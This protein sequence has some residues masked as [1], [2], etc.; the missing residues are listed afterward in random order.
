MNRKAAGI[1]LSIAG[2]ALLAGILCRPSVRPMSPER[3]VADTP[4]AGAASFSDVSRPEVAASQPRSLPSA[5]DFRISPATSPANPE[6][7]I[8]PLGFDGDA[9][10][11]PGERA[12]SEKIVALHGEAPLTAD[13]PHVAAAIQI[14]ERHKELMFHPAVV[15]T[16]IGLNDDGEI[17]LIVYTK[18]DA[19][20]IP[21]KIEELPVVVWKSG[22]FFA[23]QQGPVA[24]PKPSGGTT[25]NPADRFPRPVPIGVSTGHP[26]ITAGTIGCRIKI[27]T[28]LFALSNNH[29]FA[30]ENNAGIGDKA[31]Q[32]GPYDGA[33]YGQPYDPE[34]IIGTLAD[35]QPIDFSGA[36]NVMDAAIVSVAEGMVD[37]KTPSN[38]YGIPSSSLGTV[39]LTAKV[40]KYGRTTGQTNGKIWGINATTNV[41]YDEGTARFV[42]QIIV[43]PGNFS[44]GGDSG[45]LIVTSSGKKPVGLLFAGSASV[46]IANPIGPI[47]VR[48]N[49]AEIDGQ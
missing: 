6:L 43:N 30:N 14:Q 35:F 20:E 19:P 4:A 18:V 41:G 33:G 10:F 39:A 27:G 23:R 31:L 44:A 8:A 12:N 24:R 32:P 40:V 29:V 21:R 28:A 3:H 36:D 25:V 13:H 48:F 46:T 9:Q 37:K 45:S 22:E 2:V 42:G 34:D 5:A 38:G 7:Q 11:H 17:A 26:L 47:L 1:I 49:N 15:G 16:A